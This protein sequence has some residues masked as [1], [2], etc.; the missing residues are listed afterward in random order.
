MP[1]IIIWHEFPFPN[2][3]SNRYDF[4]ATWAKMVL[5]LKEFVKNN[6]YKLIA[7]LGVSPYTTHYYYILEDLPERMEITNQI[8]KLNYIWY[9][10]G[11]SCID[12]Q[13]LLDKDF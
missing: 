4:N 11:Q 5:E 13:S 8:L 12:Y 9:L 6:N 10:N 3:T 1:E 7:I 2:D